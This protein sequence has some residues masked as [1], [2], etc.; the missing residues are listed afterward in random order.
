M[1]MKQLLYSLRPYLAFIHMLVYCQKYIYKIYKKY[2]YFYLYKN[3]VLS[4]CRHL[5]G[6]TLGLYGVSN[7]S[8]DCDNIWPDYQLQP[9]LGCSKGAGAIGRSPLI[10]ERTKDFQIEMQR[11]QPSDCLQIWPEDSSQFLLTSYGHPVE[12]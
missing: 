12:F 6:A 2:M 7:C 10:W 3:T 4:L 9:P 8:F 1:K 11:S 5:N